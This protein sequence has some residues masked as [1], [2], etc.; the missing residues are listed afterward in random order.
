M[1]NRFNLNEEEKKH[2]RGLHNINEQVVGYGEQG[3]GE[4]AGMDTPGG[5]PDYFY[6]DDS[7]DKLR[8]F[9]EEQDSEM[10][11]EDIVN[12]LIGIYSYSQDGA[13][14]LVNTALETLIT[15]LGGFKE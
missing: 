12:E 13:T 9:A 6:G 5:N 8:K 3:L 1:K 15:N 4:D 14:D 11:K 2:I 10:S 7:L